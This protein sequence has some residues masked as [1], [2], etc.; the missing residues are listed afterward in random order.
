MPT[1]TPRVTVALA[2]FNERQYLRGAVESVLAQTFPDFELF[3]VDDGSTDG[4][5]DTL[6][7]LDDPRI[8]IHRQENQG[9]ATAINYILDHALGDYVCLQDGDDE[10]NP[11]RLEAQVAALDAHPELG[12]VFCRH[13]LIVE[14]HRRAPRYRG[15]GPEECA[16]V[17]RRV[18]NPGLDPTIM[19]RREA[20]AHLRFDPELRIGEGEDNLLRIGEEFPMMVVGGCH[21]GYRIH[22]GNASKGAGA[23]VVR[24]SSEKRARAFA[25]RG[26]TPV[27]LKNSRRISRP[28]HMTTVT[29]HV[30]ASSVELVALRRR[31]EALSSGL[32]HLRGIWRYWDSWLPLLYALTP[33]PI[34]KRRRPDYQKLL[35]SPNGYE[36]A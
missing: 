1:T 13:E 24:Y 20:T 29:G 15:A 12:A 17:I 21:Y 6:A 16:D 30:A 7:D 18:G 28:E 35:D 26:E 10:S 36:F 14:G 25:R 2:A 33:R 3:I 9:K 23:D 8:R 22:S 11:R 19:F 34:L 27:P 5:L 31:R 32:R 4:C